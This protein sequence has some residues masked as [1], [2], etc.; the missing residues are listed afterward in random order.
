MY[1]DNLMSATINIFSKI[2]KYDKLLF[3]FALIILFFQFEYHKTMSLVPHSMHNWR[4]SDCVAFAMMYY[5]H[6]MNF[7]EPKVFNLL[8]GEGHAVGECPI[9]YY[10]VACLYKLFGPSEFIFRMVIFS[11]FIIGLFSLYNLTLRFT[12]DRFFAFVI[13]LLLFSSP[14]IMLYANN[15][16]CDIPSLSLTFIAW[17]FILRY[18]DDSK[19]KN[20]WISIVLFA[21][22]SLLKLNAAI[23]FVALG[24]IFFIELNG[25]QK[26]KENN[27][28][29]HIK[30]NILGFGLALLVIFIWYWWAIHYNEKH[31]VSF[32]GTKTWPGWPIWETSDEAF[33][34]TIN[35]FFA[36]SVYIFFQPTYALMLFL[37]IFVIANRSRADWFTFN[38][39]L[40]ILVGVA[41]FTFTFFFGIKD[42]I[43][44]CINLMILP[45]FIFISA[46]QI[47]KNK[48]PVTF[49]SIVFRSI[50]FVFLLVNVKYAKGT[51]DIFYHHGVQHHRVTDESFNQKKFRAFIDSIEIP[52]TD[53]VI[54]LPDKTPDGLLCIIGRQG[55]SEYNFNREDTGAINNLVKAG[56]KYLIVQNPFILSEPALGN[57]T[58][59][60]VGHYENFYVYKF[61]EGQANSKNRNGA[62]KIAERFFLTQKE[63]D[64]QRHIVG[65][66]SLSSCQLFLLSLGGGAVAIKSPNGDFV[67]CDMNNNG[68]IVVTS[69]WMGAWEV[70]DM[71]DLP[72]G[73]FA[74]KAVNG[75]YVSF[76]ESEGN[77]LR[78]DADAPGANETFLFH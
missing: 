2:K 41:L 35:G 37:L 11:F 14:L 72:N 54:C 27:I 15:F 51:L 12:K 30:N 25:W 57:Y 70:F 53:R 66:D 65:A 26:A 60:Y 63:Q 31:S 22:A 39:F 46:I 40:L 5:D 48:Y 42:N 64:G 43:Y 67:S 21:F 55:W 34:D 76:K 29:K 24:A 23:S 8:V 44:Y 17:D 56:A 69:A 75:K 77:V 19:Q 49:N 62:I 7:F 18:R 13:P 58:G 4:Q 20:F 59:N 1:S 10:F 52:K 3:L 32:L 50:I 28:F 73:G 16:L 6:G 38:I 45:V 78:A 74:L 47:I 71:E 33:L 68:K 36:D 9:I 61:G